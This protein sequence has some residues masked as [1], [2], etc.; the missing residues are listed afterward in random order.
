MKDL[1]TLIAEYNAD[2]NADVTHVLR[3]EGFLTLYAATEM[4]VFVEVH[5]E[6]QEVQ[7]LVISLEVFDKSLGRNNGTDADI[8]PVTSDDEPEYAVMVSS[9]ACPDGEEYQ[10]GFADLEEAEAFL[11]S[12]AEPAEENGFRVV[13]SNERHHFSM[14]GDRFTRLWI[15]GKNGDLDGS[16]RK[17]ESLQM[18]D[19]L[20][21]V[22]TYDAVHGTTARAVLKS[23]LPRINPIV[24][25]T[26]TRKLDDRHLKLCFS[27][28]YSR[29]VI[30]SYG[31]NQMQSYCDLDCSWFEIEF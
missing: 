26:L 13:V 31:Y 29:Q 9:E 18:F 20:L 4:A 1:Q 6:G 25:E 5:Q 17:L 22:S 15:I 24:S 3:G 14:R 23:V 10:G 16:K 28:Y 11:S 8:K 21:Q 27:R 7:S 12:M 2:H 19:D 30:V